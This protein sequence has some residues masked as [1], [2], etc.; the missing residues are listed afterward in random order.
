MVS[1]KDRKRE[2][3]GRNRQR[4]GSAVRFWRKGLSKSDMP[5]LRFALK[6]GAEAAG[7]P[8]SPPGAGDL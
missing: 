7:W 6:A 1:G 5:L 8:F 3:G 2:N 4:V